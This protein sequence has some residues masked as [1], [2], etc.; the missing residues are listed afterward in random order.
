MSD[1]GFLENTGLLD[2][3]RDAA[4]RRSPDRGREPQARPGEFQGGALHAVRRRARQSRAQADRQGRDQERGRSGHDTAQSHERARFHRGLRPRV[5]DQLRRLRRAICACTRR[6]AQP[7]TR[8]PDGCSPTTPKAGSRNRSRRPRRPTRTS[9][10]SCAGWTAPA[11]MPT[12]L[13][14][15]YHP[16]NRRKRVPAAHPRWDTMRESVRDR[17]ESHVGRVQRWWRRRHRV[18]GPR[19]CAHDRFCLHRGDDSVIRR[20]ARRA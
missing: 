15:G 19:A 17:G 13:R 9:C 6:P 7:A 4:T 11:P 8:P 10:G 12:A 2:D 5:R 1:G 3:S 18:D 20:A 14:R 16:R